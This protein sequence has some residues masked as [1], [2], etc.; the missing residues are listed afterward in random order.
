MQRETDT[1]WFLLFVAKQQ[2][3]LSVIHWTQEVDACGVVWVSSCAWSLTILEVSRSEWPPHGCHYRWLIRLAFDTSPP[4]LSTP[5]PSPIPPSSCHPSF[6]RLTLYQMLTSNNH[7]SLHARKESCS[8][9]CTVKT[10]NKYFIAPLYPHGEFREFILGVVS[11]TV[12]SDLA[13][14]IVSVY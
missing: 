7:K 12:F 3:W 6:I 5:P 13:Y 2:Y 14:W 11:C 9:Y 4:P 1:G 10:A 8:T